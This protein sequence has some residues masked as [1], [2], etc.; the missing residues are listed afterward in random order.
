[1]S[2]NLLT[3]SMLPLSAILLAADTS[4]DN[5]PGKAAAI[6]AE[7]DGVKLTRAEFERKNASRLFQARNTYHE[8]ERKAIEEFLDQYLLERQAE[9]EKITVDQLIER[10]VTSK[11]AGD[12]SDEALRFYYEGLDTKESFEQLRGKILDHVRQ[13][14]IAKG[15]AAYVQTLRAQSN[16][17]ISLSAPRVQVSL[18]D[19]KVR[20]A[21]DARVLFVEYADYECPYCQQIQPALDKIYAEYKDRVAFAYKDLPL[22]MHA[23]AQKASEAA[24]CA[25][26]QDKYWEYHDVLVSAKQ[27]DV[28]R[29]K[30]I[31]R[32]LKLDGAS[33]DKCVDSGEKAAVIKAHMDEAQ[34]LG[35]QGT[36]SFFINGRFFSGAL[37]Y[38]KLREILEEELSVFEKEKRTAQR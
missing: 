28:P 2:R 19:T 27:L 22:P 34:A 37:S 17:V 12:P 23:N 21:K 25:G 38:E 20:G 6:I 8:A 29:L 5:G 13:R 1:M 9:K 15:K 11:L 26:V 14:R 18:K 24:H 4:G 32:E 35:L 16:V 30:E 10:H 7:I 31:A 33:F 36:P 3:L